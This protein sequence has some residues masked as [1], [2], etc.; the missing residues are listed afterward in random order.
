[1]IQMIRF[2]LSSSRLSSVLGWLFIITLSTHLF[3]PP[4]HAQEAL[5]LTTSPLPITL[6]AKPGTT[7]STDLRIRNSGS[8]AETLKVGL[9][10]FSADNQTGVAKLSERQASDDYF[11]WVSFSEQKFRLAPNEWK[12][13]KM[14]IKVPKE[15]AFG[16]YYAATFTKDTPIE[17]GTQ[18]AVVIGS[19]ATLVLLEAESPNARRDIKLTD[20]SL[21]RSWYEFLP[22]TFTVS[23]Q[24]IGNVHAMA[25]GNIFI[26]QG[27]KL[28]DTLEVNELQGNILPDSLRQFTTDW[29]QGFPYYQ[30]KTDNAG[31][32]L[33]Q[34]NQLQ[35]ELHWDFSQ[36]DKLRAGKYQAQLVMAYDNGQ[37]DVPLEASLEFW[38][39]PWRL[40][41]ASLVIG[42]LA[43]FGLYASSRSL[44]HN[45]R[46]RD[47]G[48]F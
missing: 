17:A 48:A 21:N 47:Q 18:Q 5:R 22:A 14:T 37:H 13:V 8:Q 7:V 23:L 44:W 28:I 26:Y 42:G 38:V 33:Y 6:A 3:S 31:N 4:A 40:I 36:V 34:D 15:A 39:I 35:Q 19:T 30:A 46:S 27:S 10:K 9:L 25:S 1:M 29:K 45:L 2:S 41:L 16:Y 12:T 24:N 32:P 43:L 20:F 11:D